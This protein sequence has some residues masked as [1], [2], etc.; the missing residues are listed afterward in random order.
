[1]S[2]ENPYASNTAAPFN[3]AIDTL[4]RLGQLLENIS[5]LDSTPI[6]P[7]EKQPIKIAL[8]QNLFLQAVPLLSE[9][10]SN[11]YRE[12]VLN[13]KPTEAK[14]MSNRSGISKPIGNKPIFSVQ[15]EKELNQLVFDIQLELQREKYFMPPKKDL[16]TI[17]GRM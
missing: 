9:D 15:L 2:E 17:V 5:R 8:V 11:K 3:M 14:V 16:R 6:S 10:I 1:M 12:Q 13:L 7:N 4:R